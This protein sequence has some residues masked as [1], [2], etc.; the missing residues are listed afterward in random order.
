MWD[1]NQVLYTAFLTLNG[2]RQIH[3]GGPGFIPLVSIALYAAIHDLDADL[4][5]RRIRACDRA[6]LDWHAKVEEQRE[7]ARNQRSKQRQ[8]HHR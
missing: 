2:D 3:M 4:L 5:T 1:E 7:N 6:F 8:V